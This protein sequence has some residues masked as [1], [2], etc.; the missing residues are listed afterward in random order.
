MTQ[1]LPTAL[2]PLHNDSEEMQLVRSVY[3][4]LC[5]E[6]RGFTVVITGA[7][8]FGKSSFLR[9]IRSFMETENK[10]H[11]EQ[12]D[13][14]YRP[15]YFLY[16]DCQELLGTKNV[17]ELQPFGPFRKIIDQLEQKDS[18]WTFTFRTQGKL[19]IDVLWN[20]LGAKLRSGGELPFKDTV[21]RLHRTCYDFLLKIRSNKKSEPYGNL[22]KFFAAFESRTAL[23][24]SE[25]LMEKIVQSLCA[26]A[27]A[28]PIVLIFDNLHACDSQTRDCFREI[29]QY[30]HL[31]PDT[32]LVLICAYNEND[33]NRDKSLISFET[34]RDILRHEESSKHIELRKFTTTDIEQILHQ[35]CAEA[36]ITPSKPTT[37][38]PEIAR[39]LAEKTDGKP[40]TFFR[41]LEDTNLSSLLQMEYAS[42]EATLPQNVRAVY[43]HKIESLSDHDRLLMT[44]AC[45]EGEK[46]TLYLLAKMLG[47]EILPLVQRLRLVS[48]QT[49]LIKST[50]T[51]HKYNLTTTEYEFTDGAFYDYL[52]SLL[53]YEERQI[54]HRQY[55]THLKTLFDS[56]PSRT[57]AQEEIAPFIALHAEACEDYATMQTML[58]HSMQASANLGAVEE[59]ERLYEAYIQA[60]EEHPEYVTPKEYALVQQIHKQLHT[61]SSILIPDDE[62]QQ[63]LHTNFDESEYA[64]QAAAE[65]ED[66]SPQH[67]KKTEEMLKLLGSISFLDAQAHVQKMLRH[68]EF[69]GAKIFVE[70]Y[71]ERFEAVLMPEEKSQWNALSA[72]V[73]LHLNQMLLAVATSEQARYYA[74]MV[75]KPETL[76]LAL[77]IGAVV[78]MR[79]GEYES[80]L[81]T[82][83]SAFAIIAS[84]NIPREYELLLTEN[85][86]ECLQRYEPEKM[87]AMIHAY[88]ECAQDLRRSIGTAAVFS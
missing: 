28:H 75:K 18:F 47:S 1:A 45:A 10:K 4:R 38:L 12:H 78:A 14:T 36:G 61:Q 11:T 64:E 8:Q 69:I 80:A 62:Q 67:A 56:A 83:Q 70:E 34:Y 72:L 52:E 35:R 44:I 26:L 39:I 73:Y 20:T 81:A 23:T 76:C 19:V 88:Q 42:I 6:G 33:V 58:Y 68:Q 63:T 7:H 60:A 85:L 86:V 30:L 66:S 13:N 53:E 24:A 55:V 3:Q 31:H 29:A 82:L 54:L 51:T 77:N 32:P 74:E 43:R 48:W 25:N 5:T 50:G 84:E 2:H 59:T 49:E 22:D 15:A 41:F 21:N 65:N 17:T 87:A 27:K 9:R 46:F 40:G 37:T 71:W 79:Q 16:T 57:I